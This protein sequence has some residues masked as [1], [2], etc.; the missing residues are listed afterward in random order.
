MGAQNGEDDNASPR[1]KRKLARPQATSYIL[2][3]L[4]DKVP[5]DTEGEEDV[6]ITCVEYWSEF[7][8]ILSKKYTYK[9]EKSTL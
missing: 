6:H 5:L 4:L 9:A 7:Y 8:F 2:R 1:K 3:K